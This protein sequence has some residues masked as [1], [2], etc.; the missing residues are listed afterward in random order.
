M[1]Y[2]LIPPPSHLEQKIL[3]TDLKGSNSF[4]N[5][6]LNLKVFQA[7]PRPLAIFS[8]VLLLIVFTNLPSH[9]FL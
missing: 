5:A 7:I 6:L 8:C 9:L 4:A 2:C 1:L 3:D